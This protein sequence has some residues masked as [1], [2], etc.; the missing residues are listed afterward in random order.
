MI[1][2]SDSYNYVEGT[3]PYYVPL[4]SLIGYRQRPESAISGDLGGILAENY[5]HSAPS[6]GVV[7]LRLDTVKVQ[8]PPPL[9]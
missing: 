8:I 6:H 1:H 4:T 3:P 7:W 9:F 5:R 2:S